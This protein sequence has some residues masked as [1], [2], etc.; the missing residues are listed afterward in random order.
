[1]IVVVGASPTA[2]LII[3]VQIWYVIVRVR[4]ERRKDISRAWPCVWDVAMVEL[5]TLAMLSII[6]RRIPPDVVMVG[7]NSVFVSV[8][9]R[10]SSSESWLF[11][12]SPIGLEIS[13]F[14]SFSLSSVSQR[15]LTS[16][17][18]STTPAKSKVLITF[19]RSSIRTAFSSKANFV[20]RSTTFGIFSYIYPDC[21]YEEIL[22][23]RKA[24]TSRSRQGEKDPDVSISATSHPSWS[25]SW[26]AIVCRAI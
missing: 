9:V 17:V 7:G 4:R 24:M 21:R 3:R 8:V 12:I 22:P 25:M 10:S 11:G 20:C 15:S 18:A 6:I 1:M 14:C 16:L 19:T 26:L 5:V 23:K 2:A 13:W